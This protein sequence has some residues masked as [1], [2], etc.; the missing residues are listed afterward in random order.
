MKFLHL[1]DLHLGKR[2]NEFS[3]IEDQKFILKEVLNVI[4]ENKVQSVLLAGDIY[5]K[6]V[7]PAEAV[8]LLN[9]FLTKLSEKNI[10]VFAIS[11]NHDSAER[12]GF[13]ADIMSSEGIY[14]AKP[15]DGTLSK[16]T[17][18]DEYGPLNIYMLP[19]V[20]PAIVRHAHEKM[21]FDDEI[22]T[23]DDAIKSIM[24]HT[25]IDESERN[26]LIAHQFVTGGE[27]CD[28]ENI[29]VGGV[30]E[31]SGEH[32]DRFDY[33][34]LGHLHGP[35]R[36][37][38]DK[39]RYAGT[40]LKYSFSEVNHKKSALLVDVNEKGNVEYS[41][42][43]VKPMHDMEIIEGTYDELTAKSFYQDKDRFNY[44]HAVLTDEDEKINAMELLRTIYPNIMSLEY[45]NRRT[46]YKQDINLDTDVEGKGPIDLFEELFQIQNNIGFNDS[47][48]ELLQQLEEEIWE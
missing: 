9:D 23:Y 13:G 31:V 34:A 28:S 1:A 21:G 38:S 4:D 3:M 22:V 12:I 27:K 8:L 20:K 33:V 7:P 29:S 17:L 15:Y 44:I 35:Q 10:N 45:K 5:D 14:M 46:S 47:Q 32:F 24:E 30:D 11:G 36:V 16:I 37:H 19:F 41:A 18:T 43:P 26:I 42:I 48:R 39:I 25:D 6:P 2:V 40:L